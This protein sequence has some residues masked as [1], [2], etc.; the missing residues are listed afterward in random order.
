MNIQKICVLGGTGFVGR[1]LTARLANQGYRIK[2][3]SRHPQRHRSIGVLPNTELVGA[4]VHDA[5]VLLEKFSGCDAVI[6]LVAI[7]HEQG[8]QRFKAVHADL[9]KKV[10]E[11]CRASGAKR[12]LHM[13]ALRADLKGPSQYLSTKGE[14]E[15]TVMQAQDL[16][17][18]CFK[19]SIIFGPDDTF[20][21]Q[22]AAMLRLFPALPLA[23]PDAKFAPIYVGDVAQAFEAALENDDTIGQTYELCGPRVYTF[24]EVIED[25]ARMLGLKRRVIGLPDSLARL[26]AKIMGLLPVK[27]FTTDNYLSLQADSVCTSN[28]LEALGIT[29]H[30]VDSI[31]RMH[32]AD[33]TQRRR[34]DALRQTASRS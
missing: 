27:V 16:A 9:A 11:A 17:V 23:C 25:T 20:Y 30:S 26:Q 14:A 28:G 33:K 4:D 2:V 24:R 18:T 21:N 1:H 3:L 31:M 19:P 5:T 32:L 7:L 22:F 29:P 10:I 8:S 13:S 6:N 15:Q 12:L 34:Y